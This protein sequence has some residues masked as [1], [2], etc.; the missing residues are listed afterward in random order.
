MPTKETVD[1]KA[2]K[3]VKRAAAAEGIGR[4]QNNGPIELAEI[5]RAKEAGQAAIL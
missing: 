2:P 4:K 3:D 5:F 1:V